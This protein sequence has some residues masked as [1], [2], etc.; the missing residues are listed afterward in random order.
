M[1]ITMVIIMK[2]KTM[3]TI[4]MIIAVTAIYDYD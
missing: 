1:T 4:L 2:I 3:T